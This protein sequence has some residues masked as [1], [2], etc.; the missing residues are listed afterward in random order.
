MVT[1]SALSITNEWLKPS[2]ANNLC[3]AEEC[4]GRIASSNLKAGAPVKR[5]HVHRERVIERGDRVVVRC[6]VGGVVISMQ[7][8]A[9]S[10]GSVGDEVELRKP[11]ERNTF[12]ATVSGPGEAVMDLSRP[13]PARTDD[14][15]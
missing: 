10:D 2:V 1:E 7:A 13:R 11:G 15:N 5:K 14:K 3:P 4:A 6:L 9:R 12:F 8:E